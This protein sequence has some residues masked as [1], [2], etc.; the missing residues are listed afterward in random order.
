M[1]R[2]GLSWMQG[3][4]ARPR[5]APTAPGRRRPTLPW[6]ESHHTQATCEQAALHSSKTF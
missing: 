4:Q 1:L 2:L 3:R 5:Q 6:R